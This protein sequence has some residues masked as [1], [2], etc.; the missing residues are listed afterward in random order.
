M[1][2]SKKL[3]TYVPVKIET[4]VNN[5]PEFGRFTQYTIKDDRITVGKVHVVDTMTGIKVE[6][7]ENLQP[8]LYSKFGYLADQIEVE[9]C[10]KRD[11]PYFE[12]V[13]NAALNSHALHYLRGKRFFS[14]FAENEVK[15]VIAETPKGEKYNTKFL[16]FVRM[17]MPQDLIEKYIEKIKKCPLILK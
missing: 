12:I 2:Y 14:E 8:E 10:M 16:G 13:S 1:I 11:L 7:I 9:H 15:R 3:Q 17:Y 6:Y 4:K 5:I